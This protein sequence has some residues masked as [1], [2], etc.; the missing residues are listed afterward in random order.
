[1]T[2]N[3]EGV[4]QGH[5]VRARSAEVPVTLAFAHS[6]EETARELVG[7]LDQLEVRRPLFVFGRTGRELIGRSLAIDCRPRFECALFQASGALLDEVDMLERAI[8][9]EGADVVVSCG[10]GQTLDVG[11]F[12]AFRR[13]LPFI[14][15]PTQATHDGICSPVAVLRGPGD[16]RASSYGARTPAALVVPLHVI[17]HAP[18]PTLLSGM[19]DLAANVIAVEDW[20]W[21]HQFRDEPYDHYAALLARSAAQLVLGRRHLLSRDAELVAED[22]E[23]L[24][25]GLVL[26]GLAMTLAGSSRPCSG[27][28]HLISHAFDLLGLGSG[29]HGEQVGVGSVLAVRLYAADLNPVVELLRATGAPMYPAD[30]GIATDD[31]ARA[32]KMAHLVRPERHSRLSSAIIADPDFIDELIESAWIAPSREARSEA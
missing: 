32:V 7:T 29:T 9:A 13:R 3:R 4:V 23:S 26:S 27:P 18:R 19:A 11:K 22:I 14:S 16:A 10:G 2:D 28:E 17:A 12:A 20:L 1:M 24:V 31:A 30:L 5:D 25:H 21:A 8:A 6:H 15:V